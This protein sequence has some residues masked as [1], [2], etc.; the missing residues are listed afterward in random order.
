MCPKVVC[1][2][3]IHVINTC[4]NKIKL[5]QHMTFVY[6]VNENAIKRALEGDTLFQN[7]KIESNWAKPPMPYHTHT[8]TSINVQCVQ[9]HI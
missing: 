3:H 1:T 8:H 9:T 6:L 7:N 5:R 4:K 2:P